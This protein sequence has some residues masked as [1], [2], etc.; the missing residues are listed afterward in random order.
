MAIPPS[1]P[2]FQLSLSLLNS[3]PKRKVRRKARVVVAELIISATDS[4][5]G[6]LS[7]IVRNAGTETID[8]IRRLAFVPPF[9]NEAVCLIN[10]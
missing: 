7:C 8:L 9:N 10:Q 1:L 2:N 6:S 4:H 3:D 5:R